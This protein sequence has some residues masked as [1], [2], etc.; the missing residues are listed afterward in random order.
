VRF[1]SDSRRI[2]T[3]SRDNDAGIWNADTGALIATLEG[4]TD[5]VSSAVFSPDGSFVVTASADWSARL[6]DAATGFSFLTLARQPGGAFGADLASD[7]ATVI[8]TSGM[9]T[10]DSWRVSRGRV[11]AVG[12]G[13]T[14]ERKT[15]ELGPPIPRFFV[16]DDGWLT[17]MDAHTDTGRVLTVATE[18]QVIDVWEVASETIVRRL[19]GH[20]AQVS[21]VAFSADGARVASGDLGG[22]VRLWDAA[23]GEQLHVLECHD[24][25]VSSVAF[26]ADGSLLVSAG[27]MGRACVWDVEAGSL[28]HAVSGH[29]RGVTVTTEAIA[30]DNSIFV[31]SGDDGLANVWDMQSGERLA[32]LR[33]GGAV[34]AYLDDSGER[35][36]AASDDRTA[37]LWNARTGE[38]IIAFEGH[39]AAVWGADMDTEGRLLLTSAMDGVRLWEVSSGAL[40]GKLAGTGGW[41]SVDGR[42]AGTTSGAHITVWDVTPETRDRDA[43]SA[44]IGDNVPYECSG[45]RLVATQTARVKPHYVMYRRMRME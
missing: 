17:D 36:I 29:T 20:E 32:S 13:V 15:G 45:G 22:G 23:S 27:N 38:L 25:W 9:A 5:D 18:S 24:K 2:V 11:V 31:T 42:R 28:L 19:T 16:P 4:H 10:V 39:D 33:H 12:E 40:V 44:L 3:A 14:F 37:R 26:S 6:W 30:K 43:V 41:L 35:V 8:T 21:T 34:R 1:S 7:G